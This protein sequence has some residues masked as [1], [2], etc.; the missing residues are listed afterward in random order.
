[1]TKRKITGAVWLGAAVWAAAFPL[2]AASTA[3]T[4]Q[5]RLAAGGS[6]ANGSYDF[7]FGLWDAVA[8]GDDLAFPLVASSIQVTGGV[9]TATIDFG[10]AVFNG[11]NLWLEL[12]VSPSGAGQFTTLAPR[13]ALAPAPLAIYAANA[14]AAASAGTLTTAL[15][16]TQL[17][18]VIPAALLPA[19]VV[20]NNASGVSLSGAFSGSGAGLTNIASTSLA[21]TGTR[22]YLLAAV[23][24]G[25]Y[26]MISVKYNQNLT[27]TN[28][29]VLWPD[30]TYGVWTATNL[31]P[32][33]FTADGY[34]ITYTNKGVTIAQP[35]V[36]RDQ[37]G[38]VTNAPA[39]VVGP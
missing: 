1:M 6:P 22:T 37:N 2:R 31:N 4:Y 34:T 28:A 18:G 5:G 21:W 30:G 16:S 26:Q 25:E 10:S 9:F 33:W 19:S 15:P 3:F 8:G 12:A 11:T 32:A 20:T 36:L 35:T 29:L 13:Q 38:N 14:G 24:A 23:A 39:L 17:S 7:R 27:P